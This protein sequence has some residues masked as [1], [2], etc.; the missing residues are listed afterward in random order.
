MNRPLYPDDPAYPVGYRRVK[1]RR[2][3]ATLATAPEDDPARRAALGR[4]LFHGGEGYP[5]SVPQSNSI[6]I[7][8]V[9]WLRESGARPGYM[10]RRH[11]RHQ[12]TR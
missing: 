1:A 3:F 9:A 5:R 6:S 12:G 10:N 7:E 2:T 4:M 11:R 8:A